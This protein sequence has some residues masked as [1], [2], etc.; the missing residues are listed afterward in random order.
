M[1][2]QFNF[3][4]RDQDFVDKFLRDYGEQISPEFKKVLTEYSVQQQARDEDLEAFL[5]EDSFAPGLGMSRAALQSVA[6]SAALI[7]D[8]QDWA[9]T[10]LLEWDGNTKIIAGDSGVY[11]VIF[12]AATAAGVGNIRGVGIR[13]NGVTS[14]ASIVFPPPGGGAGASGSVS[15]AYPL[16]AGD[17]VEGVVSQ[18]SG[19]PL[20][21][22]GNFQVIFLGNVG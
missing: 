22:T 11:Q 6:V 19:G 16:A 3:P 15:V 21:Y 7:W 13:L 17:Y 18:D 8:T 2:S 10:D 20:D 12:N 1:G 4:F 14:L 5:D 9:S